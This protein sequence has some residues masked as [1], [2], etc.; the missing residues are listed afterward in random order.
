MNALAPVPFLALFLTSVAACSEYAHGVDIDDPSK[1]GLTP[2]VES[3][4]QNG[5][6]AVDYLVAKFERHDLLLLGEEHGI[7]QNCGF[8][9]A[10]LEP[11]YHRAGVRVLATEFARTSNAERVEQLVNADE[12]DHDQALAIMRDYAWPTWGYQQYLDIL[13]A[14]WRLNST[15]PPDAE[16]FRVVPIDSGWSQHDLFYKNMSPVERFNVMMDRERHMTDVLKR[17]VLSPGRKAI[18]HVGF[19]HTLTAQGKRLGTVLRNEY[20]DRVAQVCLHHKF[21]D[22]RGASSVSRLID[23]VFEEYDAGPVGFDVAGTPFAKLRD[24][25]N[26]AFTFG[27]NRTFAEL[28]EGY[29]VLAPLDELRPVTW[30]DGFI[31]EENFE[32]ALEVAVKMGQADGQRDDTPAKLNAQMKKVVESR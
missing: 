31:T 5:K 14:A 7:R 1:I 22:P 18:T 20:G 15:L 30:I 19:L 24:P 28:A 8:I 9:A 21:S 13:E 27:G 16:P 25:R 26:Q 17:E 4:Q 23:R 10:S 12:F 2:Y 32:E 29:I 3:L 11:L 6:P